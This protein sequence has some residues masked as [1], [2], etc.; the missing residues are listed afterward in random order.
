MVPVIRDVDKKGLWQ[1]SK[2][3]IELAGKSERK[4]IKACRN[5]GRL[6]YYFQPRRHFGGTGFTPIVNTPE[7]G[8]LGVSKLSVKPFSLMVNLSQEKYY[9]FPYLMIIEQ[10]MVV[11]L[12][13]LSHLL[14]IYFGYSKAISVVSTHFH[15]KQIK[16]YLFVKIVIKFY[17]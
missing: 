10:L 8:I 1:L 15:N 17:N 2:E 7:V 12:V 11:M 4:K 3:I 9:L 5:A 13:G 16:Y 14:L 6:L